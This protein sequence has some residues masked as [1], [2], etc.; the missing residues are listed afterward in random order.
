[1]MI[2][3]TLNALRRVIEA[4]PSGPVIFGGVEALNL[5]ARDLRGSV[6]SNL[7]EHL[8][9]FALPLA[10]RRALDGASFLAEAGKQS[11]AVI[12]AEQARLYGQANYLAV[13]GRWG[14]VAELIEQQTRLEED[15][16]ASMR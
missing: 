2:S 11:A 1:M 4:N 10:A 12:Q 5:L 15:L 13:R 9:W 8:V 3:D 16:I 14:Q 7:A 6:P